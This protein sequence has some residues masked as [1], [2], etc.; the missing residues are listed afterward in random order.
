ML[1]QATPKDI[2]DKHHRDWTKKSISY[3]SNI[4]NKYPD[5]KIDGIDLIKEAVSNCIQNTPTEIDIAYPTSMKDV[6]Q[7]LEDSIQTMLNNYYKD[8]QARV[9]E[10]RRNVFNAKLARILGEVGHWDVPEIVTLEL[11]EKMDRL[12]IAIQDV[13]N[14]LKRGSRDLD[15]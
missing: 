4:L 9:E 14:E 12:A 2:W 3:I 13:Q 8:E 11:L 5:V 10:E 7:K 15:S 1:K 6:I